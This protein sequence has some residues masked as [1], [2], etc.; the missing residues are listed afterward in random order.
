[1]AIQHCKWKVHQN[2]DNSLDL[3][4]LIA[5][6]GYVCF[7]IVQLRK[8]RKYFTNYETLQDSGNDNVSP[9]KICKIS[10]ANQLKHLKLSVSQFSSVKS[11]KIQTRC[12]SRC[13]RVLVEKHWMMMDDLTLWPRRVELFFLTTIP[14]KFQATLLSKNLRWWCFFMHESMV[15]VGTSSWVVWQGLGIYVCIWLHM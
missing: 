15:D 11:Q 9:K 7:E 6:Y 2:I 14:S 4:V 1:M 8:W 10:N 3:P 5:L 13:H 12:I